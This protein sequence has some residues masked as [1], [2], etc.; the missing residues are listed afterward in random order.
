M[1]NGPS[2]ILKE[3]YISNESRDDFQSGYFFKNLFECVWLVSS[4]ERGSHCVTS[5]HLTPPHPAPPHQPG[6][7]S[8]GE[9]G[10]KH[11]VWDYRR[12]PPCVLFSYCFLKYFV[13]II[14]NYVYVR[15]GMCGCL[16]R[17]GM[18]DPSEL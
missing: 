2:K 16:Q 3:P 9:A 18:S 5:P 7:Y 4:F 11:E 13:S 10:H 14:F 6:I 1:E 15:V 8:T 12:I 17:P